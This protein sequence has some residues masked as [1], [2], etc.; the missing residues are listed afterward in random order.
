[1]LSNDLLY[2]A[3]SSNEGGFYRTCDVC[4]ED[5]RT[6]VHTID[7]DLLLSPHYFTSPRHM[8]HTAMGP[9]STTSSFNT[10]TASTANTTALPTPTLAHYTQ[11][12]DNN[13]STPHASGRGEDV[14]GIEGA[15][16]SPMQRSVSDM[17]ELGECPV[18]GTNLETI[19]DK[20]EQ[21][22]HVQTCLESG[23]S[24]RMQDNR[25]LG[26]QLLFFPVC[27]ENIEKL[28]LFLAL[29]GMNQQSSPCLNRLP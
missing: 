11:V 29:Y 27:F 25:Y 14:A 28:I 23:T 10:T 19:P 17:S 15:D 8:G 1:M 21:E 6:A 26:E 2:G 3:Y 18:C 4:H 22:S 20:T 12:L 7:P 13:H 5:I 16:G 9:T 24:S